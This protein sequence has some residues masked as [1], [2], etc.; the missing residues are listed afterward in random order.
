MNNYLKSD[1]IIVRYY[2]T[3]YSNYKIRP[4]VVINSPHPSEDLIIVPITSRL[5]NLFKGEFIIENWRE[6]GLNVKSAIKRAIFTV[7]ERIVISRVGRLETS[8]NYR[9]ELS[10]KN[11]LGLT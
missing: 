10:I 6:S 4:A 7:S 1:I 3:D 2:F 8:D 5:T 11:W 9:L